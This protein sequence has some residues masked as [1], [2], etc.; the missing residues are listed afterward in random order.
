MTRV[1][2]RYPIRW[3]VAG[4]VIAVSLAG[5]VGVLLSARHVAN[6]EAERQARASAADAVPAV[7]DTLR[8]ALENA[9]SGQDP[10]A[11][12]VAIADVGSAGIASAS[13]IQARDTGLP[14]LDDSGDGVVVVAAYDQPTP[15]SDVQQRREHVVGYRV[16]P[17]ALGSTLPGLQPPSGG[18][19][20]AG[21]DR[22]VT[23]TGDVSS[24][25]HSYTV[26]LAPGLAA[27]WS[28]TTWSVSKGISAGAWLTAMAIILLGVLATIWLLRRSD[29]T[30]RTQRD[31][32]QLQER[33]SRLAALASVS[34]HS[35]DLADVLPA[36][37]TELSTALGL[38]G[39]ALS[40]PT[41]DG[42]RLFFAWGE[43]PADTITPYTLPH[44]LR[45]GDSLALVL[46]RGGRS[47]AK[48]LL[49]AGRDLDT[50][51][52]ST[53]GA[54]A[55]LL[56]SAVANAEA[57]AQQRE[58]LQRM[59]AL[60]ELKTVF[61]A[62]ASHELRTP[63]GAITGFARM[64]S[65][66]WDDLTPE[67]GRMYADRVD[68]NAQRLGLLVEDLL[69]FSRMEQGIGSENT[70]QMLDLGEVISRILN[71]QPHLAT[72]HEL[73]QR[74]SRGVIVRGSAQALERVVSNL[75]SNAAKYSPVGTTIR[76]LVSRKDGR[77]ELAVEDDG[78]GVPAPER[79][80]IFSRFFRGKGDVV[81]NTRGAGLGLAIVSEFAASMGGKVS[82]TAA[83][84]GGARFVVSYPI[85]D[86]TRVTSEGEIHVDS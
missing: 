60:D 22:R 37:T 5:A 28:V 10:T 71:E 8:T 70:S 43:A 84:S 21:P 80:Q 50:S 56:T 79:E 1:R 18:I 36:V 12:H 15:P 61:L 25:A 72:D 3:V 86:P 75:V 45:A 74:M 69:D 13:V 54:A 73:V 6:L 32:L 31:L 40:T 46:S 7:S 83:S 81:I 63:V 16:V 26:K 9:A 67:Q 68:R 77:A 30:R 51:D 24:S 64:L 39:L 65:S 14:V 41:P 42:E 29:Q 52:M 44:E 76:V 58:L 49:L 34:Q 82:V 23:T 59:R 4:I 57:F 48:L 17:L 35:L 53:L 19:S 85:A 2:D 62:T 78:P 27:D 11:K 38:R 66:K 33:S 47:V 55:D 20:V